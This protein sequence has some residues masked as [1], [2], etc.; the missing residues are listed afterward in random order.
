MHT[1]KTFRLRSLAAA[2][3]A[4]S[5]LLH[6]CAQAED[7]PIAVTIAALDTKLR[8][9]TYDVAAT[10]V[11]R[12]T[13][14]LSSEISATV[15]GVSADVGAVV[16]KGSL[17]ISLDQTDTRLALQRAQADH[18]R[19]TSELALA[20]TRLARGEALSEQNFVS[21]DELSDLATQVAIVSA[22]LSSAN[23]SIAEAEER[24]KDTRIR[25]PFDA[26]VTARDA[27]LGALVTQGQS[28]ITVTEIAGVEVAAGVN[29]VQ[30]ASLRE[31]Q[32]IVFVSDSVSAA[33]TLTRASPVL[34]AMNRLHAVRLNSESDIVSGQSGRLRWQSNAEFI[35]ASY[36]QRRGQSLGVFVVDRD[37]N[38]R[39]Q[40]V[41][42]DAAQEG[43]P[44][45]SSLP[46]DARIIES[47][48]EK[49]TDGA[50]ITM[51]GQ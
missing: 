11:A 32:S 8:G 47:G 19:L 17:L 48:R 45:R 28:M 12:N 7:T 41:V 35:P 13:S 46:L 27:Q 43:R 50:L 5:L 15:T 26:V 44:V 31:A 24:L 6:P 37:D 49:L 20:E 42:I 25:A 9:V 51:Q 29:S 38:T 23:F 4:L 18:A 3:A 22:Q 1:N 2:L 14:V 21:P 10:A 34:D 36:I 39:A 40:F 16:A 33:V 30:L